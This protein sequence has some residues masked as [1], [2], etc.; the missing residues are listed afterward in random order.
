MTACFYAAS[1]HACWSLAGKAVRTAIPTCIQAH[2]LNTSKSSGT[3]LRESIPNKCGASACR[4]FGCRPFQVLRQVRQCVC[5]HGHD[6][7]VLLK[8]ARNDFVE[9]VRSGMVIVKVEAVILYGTETGDAKFQQGANVCL[10]A[11]NR[12]HH[13]GAD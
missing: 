4:R 11:F 2:T 6:G 7:Y 12:L 5:H 8:F 3:R 13:T 1:A 9:R 10:R